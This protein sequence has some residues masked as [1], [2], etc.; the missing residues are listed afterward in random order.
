M[1]GEQWAEAANLPFLVLAGFG[2]VAFGPVGAA[3]ILSSNTV[4]GMRIQAP[5][6]TINYQ[7]L[8]S[9]QHIL[10]KQGQRLEQISSIDTL[11]FDKTGTLTDGKLNVSD[12]HIIQ[13]NYRETDILFYAAL[14]EHQLTHP[15][16]KAIMQH[17]TQAG[18]NV[19]NLDD[20]EYRQ[21]Y[22]IVV[23]FDNRTI[24]TS[25]LQ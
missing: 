21:G 8:A 3:V 13:S 23:Q 20:I 15:I 5:L 25:C 6:A 7:A 17:A 10:I 2:W 24:S 12:I 9:Y 16:A 4:Q 11:L 18:L 22:G 19:E 1:R 14:A